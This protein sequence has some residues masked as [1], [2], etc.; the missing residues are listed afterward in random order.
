MYLLV[1]VLFCFC[2]P[3]QEP[4]R[5]IFHHESLWPDWEY[6]LYDLSRHSSCCSI[7]QASNRFTREKK[8][9][10]RLQNYYPLESHILL[11]QILIV[12]ASNKILFTRCG[13]HHLKIQDLIIGLII[14]IILRESQRHLPT[15]FTQN[16]PI[17][18]CVNRSTVYFYIE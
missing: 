2:F 5:P 8:W 12:K 3:S 9:P 7:Y 10:H 15:F 11:I 17:S 13:H 6:E 14:T 16:N 4:L 1:F 18:V